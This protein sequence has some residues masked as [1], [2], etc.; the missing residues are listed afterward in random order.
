MAGRVRTWIRRIWILLGLGITGWLIWNMQAH[1]VPAEAL[2]STAAL[3]VENADDG[4]RFLPVDLP[5]GAPGLIFLPGGGVDPRAYV[6][7][8]RGLAEAGVPAAIVRLPFRVAPTDGT[9]SETWRRVM[10]V[11][12]G[13]GRD[14]PVVLGGHSRGAAL[15]ARFAADERPLPDALVLVGTTHPRDHDLSALAIPV[16]KVMGT[17]DCVAPTDDARA[18]AHQLPPHTVW[19]EIAGANHAQFGH[20]GSQFND[21]SAT[22]GREVQQQEAADAVQWAIARVRGAGPG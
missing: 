13:W 5:A 20:Y 22:I 17:R 9:R 14:R 8:V 21:C 6:P 10:A 2:A 7:F 12:D 18:N 19:R 15:A 16:V 1:G 3:R 11:R 4:I